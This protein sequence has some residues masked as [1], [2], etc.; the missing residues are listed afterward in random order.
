[1]ALAD[2]RGQRRRARVAGGPALAR[3]HATVLGEGFEPGH[4]PLPLLGR[5]RRVHV[6]DELHESLLPIARV[7]RVLATTAAFPID[8]VAAEP[9]RER[10]ARLV[11]PQE[12]DEL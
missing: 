6:E 9:L 12:L 10:R 4:D 1:M 2:L 3:E 5:E 11:L 8:E 7:L